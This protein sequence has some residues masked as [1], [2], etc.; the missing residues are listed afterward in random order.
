MKNLTIPFTLL[1]F[2][3][4]ML[5]LP[6]PGE[7]IRF[8]L[9]DQVEVRM[10]GSSN[11]NRWECDGKKL[12]LK[13][14][15]ILNREDFQETLQRA[16][17]GEIPL[18]L[19]VREPSENEPPP[20]TLQVPVD[21]LNC[22]RRRMQQDLR[23]AVKF[24]EH[25][26]IRYELVEIR[27]ITPVD[28]EEAVVRV[29]LAGSLYV[30]GVARKIVHEIKVARLDRETFQIHG[31]LDLKMT[32]FEMPPPTALLGLIKARDRFEVGFL[33][34]ARTE[35]VEQEVSRDLVRLVTDLH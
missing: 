13:T 32:W 33:F 29:E 6:L 9:N 18:P 26:Y 5:A 28:G 1:L 27:K 34:Q 2:G 19:R 16:W 4:G 14:S 31:Q 25:P 23:E 11:I 3:F 35:P 30:A 22:P 10:V 21:S 12:E 20:F 17:E 7:N 24:G 8:G 15:L